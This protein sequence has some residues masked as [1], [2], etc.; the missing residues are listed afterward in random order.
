MYG[1][2]LFNI[3]SLCFL[4]KTEMVKFCSVSS[5]VALILCVEGESLVDRKRLAAWKRWLGVRPS[6][7]A[8]TMVRWVEAFEEGFDGGGKVG[9]DVG[10]EEGGGDGLEEEGGGGEGGGGG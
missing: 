6:E 4:W 3:V 1:R 10:G 7:S 9:L 8:M 2:Y 5:L